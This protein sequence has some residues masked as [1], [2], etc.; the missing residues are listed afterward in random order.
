MY[1]GGIHFPTLTHL[2]LSVVSFMHIFNHFIAFAI[3]LIWRWY[4]GWWLCC[5]THWAGVFDC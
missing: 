1:Y 5:Y 4:A 2:P 3:I